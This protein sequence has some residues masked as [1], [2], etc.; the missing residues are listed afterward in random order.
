[1]RYRIEIDVPVTLTRGSS[2]WAILA[3]LAPEE[4]DAAIAADVAAAGSRASAQQAKTLK[5]ELA[6]VRAQGFALSRSSRIPGAV[7]ISAPVFKS[8]HEIY[9]CVCVTIPEQRFDSKA[10]RRLADRVTSGAKRIS[11]LLGDEAA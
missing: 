1:L 5:Q 6:T 8:N 4:I 11:S 7:G 9:G 10:S 2:G 3:Y